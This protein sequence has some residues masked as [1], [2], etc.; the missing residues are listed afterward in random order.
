MSNDD[1][2][3]GAKAPKGADT[4]GIR[5]VTPE[6]ALGEQTFD[7]A[8]FVAGAKPTHRAVT[9]YARGDLKARLDLIGE[10]IELAE[11][12]GN[13]G[14]TATLR[15]DAQAIVDEMTG[16]GAVI[17]IVVA[18]RSD[19]WIARVDEALEKDGI[20]DATEKVLRRVAEQVVAP[21]GVTYELLE[22]F[23][24]VSEPQVKKVVV[25]ATLAN[26]QAVSADVPFLRGSTGKTGGR[27]SSSR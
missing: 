23:R 10:E 8:A 26:Q 21:E 7:F 16:Q 19:D 17:D 11:R 24:Q 5:D 18:G 25:A 20:T 4:D 6:A 12:A 3:L 22:S 15:K 1:L 14:K 13:K 27:G 9:L 2:P